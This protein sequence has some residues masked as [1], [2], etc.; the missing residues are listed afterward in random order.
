MAIIVELRLCC[1]ECLDELHGNE[2]YIEDHY[3]LNASD[4]QPMVDEFGW[5]LQGAYVICNEC[6]EER[7]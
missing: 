3:Q 1:D 6:R 7:E 4:L 5:K 2:V